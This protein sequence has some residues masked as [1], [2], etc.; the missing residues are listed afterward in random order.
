M[1]SLWNFALKKNKMYGAKFA[2]ILWK[3]DFEMWIKV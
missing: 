2:E 1:A 3:F